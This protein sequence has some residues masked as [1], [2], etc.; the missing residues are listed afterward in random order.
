M[1]LKAS[2]SKCGDPKRGSS[3]ALLL[4]LLLLLS[5]VVIV[6]RLI[7]KLNVQTLSDVIVRVLKRLMTSV[8]E[9]R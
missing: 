9:L 5:G 3:L 8:L 1:E 4:L 7:I 6:L 2:S